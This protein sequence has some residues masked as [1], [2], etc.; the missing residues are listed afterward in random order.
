M[1]NNSDRMFLWF[2]GSFVVELTGCFWRVVRK[3]IE[4]VL[5]LL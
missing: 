4:T 3:L 2:L 1:D 5:P